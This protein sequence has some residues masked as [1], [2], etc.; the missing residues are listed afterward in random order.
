MT[1]TV[2]FVEV[3]RNFKH[4]PATALYKSVA[5]SVL[6]PSNINLT[7]KLKNVLCYVSL[8]FLISLSFYRT[9]YFS[10]HQINPFYLNFKNST[11]TNSKNLSTKS[12][13]KRGQNEKKIENRWPLFSQ[14]PSTQ[15]EIVSSPLFEE[16][17][18]SSPSI[19][20]SRVAREKGEKERAL[21]R[22][23]EITFRFLFY[24]ALRARLRPL[25][26]FIGAR[27]SYC[28]IYSEYSKLLDQLSLARA[29]LQQW[30]G[31]VC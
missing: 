10:T 2:K 14:L 13:K 27:T 9:V 18:N 1:K 11:K 6:N 12:T 17:E 20:K 31:L 7:E 16:L 26:S 21:R 22:P 5:K 19:T 29:L 8:L 25:Y 23:M 4:L 30:S 28:V 24:R 15:L 3:K